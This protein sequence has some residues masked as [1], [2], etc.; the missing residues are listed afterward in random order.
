MRKK[1][2]ALSAGQK[3][4]DVCYSFGNFSGGIVSYAMGSWYM[5]FYVDKLGLP[6]R[7]YSYAMIVYGIWNAIND[8]MMGIISDKTK[9]RWGRR[10]P[11]MMFGAVPLGLSLVMLFAPPQAVLS[12][13]MSLLI[14]FVAAL[15]LFDTFFTM[16]MLTWSAVLPEMYLDERNRGRVNVYSQILGVL[17]AMLATLG[18]QPIINSF[19]YGVMAVIF[20]VIGI[21]TMLMSAWGVREN[22][23]HMEKKSLTVV[24]SFKATF[25]SKSFVICVISIL[26]VE[27]GKVFCTATM[28]FYSDYVMENDLGVTIIMGVMFV[29][30]MAFAPL[31]S[32]ICNRVGAKTTY[33]IT[34][35]VFA[36]ACVGYMFAP[37]IIF[38]AFI[39][40]I[41]GFGVSGIMIMPNMLYAEIIDEDQVNTGVRRE[42]AF[43]GIN[44]LIMR[45]SVIVH[46]ALSAFVLE[47]SGYLSTLEVQPESAVFGIRLLMGGLPVVFIILAVV[48]LIFYPIDK[49]RLAEVQQKVREMNA[50][51]LDGGDKAES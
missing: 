12:Q 13:E 45:L 6:T 29:S 8:P 36:L 42:G 47:R 40:A 18:V 34:T 43:Y 28:P 16:T 50:E 9:S 49:E 35:A 39:S 20:A 44:A 46:G 3:W 14:Y 19:G 37:N 4:K 25:S 7:Y 23:V 2:Q 26:L 31:V 1:G 11:Y 21:A 48:V 38:A 33:I 17:G 24:E 10:K 27:I 22:K 51:Y 30:S 5:Y 15:C 41:V 32:Y